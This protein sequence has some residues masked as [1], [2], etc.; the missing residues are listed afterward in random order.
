[1]AT[2]RTRRADD[3]D[4]L[5]DWMNGLQQIG[6]MLESADGQLCCQE[7]VPT[8]CRL[9]QSRRGRSDGQ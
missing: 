7:S 4:P 2:I 6:L 1:M 8:V 3:V 5:V 9:L